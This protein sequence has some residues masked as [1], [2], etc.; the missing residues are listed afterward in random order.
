M[1]DSQKFKRW[2]WI[3]YQFTSSKDDP[4]TESQK[5]VP[6]TVTVGESV[7]KSERS[8]LL[9]PLIRHSFQEAEKRGESL[10]LIRPKEIEIVYSEKTD[11]E[12]SSERAKHAELAAQMSLFDATAKPLEPC[13]IQFT[14]SWRDYDGKKRRHECDD[15]ETSTAFSRFEREYGRKKAIEIIRSKYEEEYFAS[16]LALAFS[17]HSRRNVHFGKTNQWLLVGVIRIDASGQGDLLW[18]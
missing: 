13:P 14:A 6:E 2:D 3:D 17:T 9:S 1:N 16:G 7:K 8:R 4:R 11:E 5:V 18:R 10:T 15:W 12:I